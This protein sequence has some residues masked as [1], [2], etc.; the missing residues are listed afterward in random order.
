MRGLSMAVAAGWA[1]DGDEV[2]ADAGVRRDLELVNFKELLFVGLSVPLTGAGIGGHF[3]AEEAEGEDIG[4]GVDGDGA[5]VSGVIEAFR[6]AEVVD[7]WGAGGGD[8]AFMRRLAGRR[9]LLMGVRLGV[10]ARVLGSQR[11]WLA[12]RGACRRR[13]AADGVRV[14]PG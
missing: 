8:E 9:R 14:A 5:V 12:R 3:L 7:G 1:D 10:G 11:D 2:R 13:Y 6:D 4:I